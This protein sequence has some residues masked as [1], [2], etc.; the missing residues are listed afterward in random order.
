MK[1]GNLRR[2]CNARR[3]DLFVYSEDGSMK[4]CV[5]DMEHPRDRMK[6]MEYSK[7]RVERINP[8]FEIDC[9]GDPR[10]VLEVELYV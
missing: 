1:F 9:D 7:A 4:T 8:G 6:I 2:L 10:P 5:L 3:Y